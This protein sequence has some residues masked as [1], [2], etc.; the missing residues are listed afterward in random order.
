[1]D[2][3]IGKWDL[4]PCLK[5]NRIDVILQCVESHYNRSVWRIHQPQQLK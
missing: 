4:E 1:M 3:A 2:V 5:F